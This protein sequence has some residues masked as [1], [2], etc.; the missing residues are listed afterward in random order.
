MR[1]AVLERSR[2]ELVCE[3]M[4]VP[5]H[6][7]RTEDVERSGCLLLKTART[8][9]GGGFFEESPSERRLATELKGS[10]SNPSL[11]GR[12]EVSMSGCDVRGLS[13]EPDGD[14]DVVVVDQ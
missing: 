5:I 11:G 9:I 7:D 8:A 6:A 10:D 1:D 12:L 14:A 4:V 3:R 2:E 13:S